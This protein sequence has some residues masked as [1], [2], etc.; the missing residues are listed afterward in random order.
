MAIYCYERTVCLNHRDNTGA[1]DPHL[2]CYIKLIGRTRRHPKNTWPKRTINHSRQLI[3]CVFDDEN[4]SD[5]HSLFE[6]DNLCIRWAELCFLCAE[7]GK[8][9][10]CV[11]RKNEDI[12]ATA[13]DMISDSFIVGSK[14]DDIRARGG[15]IKEDLFDW[16]DFV[17]E[18]YT[19]T[20]KNETGI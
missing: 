15:W 10:L 20:R 1:R 5:K 17:I 7:K 18:L 2:C 16:P 9:L 6:K 14:S 4:N 11:S 12:P 3:N 19:F 8:R 13:P